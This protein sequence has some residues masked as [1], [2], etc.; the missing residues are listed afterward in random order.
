VDALLTSYDSNVETPPFR[1]AILESGEISYPPAPFSASND[2]SWVALT[3]ALNC[4]STGNNLTCV[5]N[6]PATTI[7]NI[8]DTQSL[9]FSPVVDNVTLVA[10][11]AG[12]RAANKTARVPVLGGTDAQEGRVFEFGSSNVTALLEQFFR[13]DA[14]QIIPSVAAAYPVGTVVGVNTGYD[15]ASQ[16]FT[17]YYFQ[18]PQALWANETAAQGVPTWRYYFNA[19]FPNTQSFPN[20]GV[21]HSSE[22]QLVFQTYSGGPVLPLTA[23]PTGILPTNIPPTAQEFALSSFMNGAWAQFMREPRVGPGWNA[24][25]TF[26]E[27]LGVLG[28]DGGAGVTV[29][30]Q[31]V[32]DSKCSLFFPAYRAIS[33]NVYGLGQ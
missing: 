5:R 1:A 13:L 20:A 3:A 28:N 18:C 26:N 22:I 33:G 30:D 21:F 7:R 19:S 6:A 29:I 10:S 14:P 9:V 24:L 23:G 16:I 32:V 31:N 25:G 2:A 4:S 15:V 8:I 27:S 11:P 12:A 17:D